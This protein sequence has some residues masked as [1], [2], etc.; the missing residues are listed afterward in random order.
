MQTKYLLPFVVFSSASTGAFT[1]DE[2]K[3]AVF[4]VA[5]LGREKGEGFFKKQAPEK[6]VFVSKVFYPFWVAPFRGLTLLLDGL[7]ISS[8]TTTYTTM[9]NL[10]AFKENLAERSATVQLYKNFLS[11][12]LNYFE[13]SGNEQTLIIEGFLDDKE[14][15]AEFTEYLKEATVTNSPV[16]DGVLVSPAYDETNLLLMLQKVENS[17]LT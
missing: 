10:Q 9:P 7:N 11:N 12:N 8:H 13:S 6:L 15:E 14:F 4:C 2:E 3:A 5:E 17:R 1:T 16:V